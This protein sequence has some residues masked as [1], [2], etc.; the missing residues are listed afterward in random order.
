MKKLENKNTTS[1]VQNSFDLP[2]SKLYV[3][4]E[5]TSEYRIRSV[6][7]VQIETNKRQKTFMKEPGCLV[8]VAARFTFTPM[9]SYLI[10]KLNKYISTYICA[11][12]KAKPAKQVTV[13]TPGEDNAVRMHHINIYMNIQI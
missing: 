5:R 2:N 6:E 10:Y 1:E 13:T 12:M 4:E 8:S 7:I 3:V 11:R 9:N